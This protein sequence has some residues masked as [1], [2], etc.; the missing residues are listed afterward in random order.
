M[1]VTSETAQ[2]WEQN[3]QYQIPVAFELPYAVS[4]VVSDHFTTCRTMDW[5]ARLER[6]W[7][8]QE[9]RKADE[10]KY[11]K[12]TWIQFSERYHVEPGRI[13]DSGQAKGERFSEMLSRLL[14]SDPNS[15]H[16]AGSAL[17][18]HKLRSTITMH[19]R[20]R[21]GTEFH[22]F[23]QLPSE[24]RNMVYGLLL[25]KGTVIV[26]NNTKN[27]DIRYVKYW[28]DH[29]GAAYERY[30]GLERE[31]K[32]L[33][34]RNREREPLF[35]LHGVS[36]TFHAEAIRVYFGNNRF[37]LPSSNLFR[38]SLFGSLVRI[39]S[40]DVQEMDHRSSKE[41]EKGRNNAPLVRDVSYT[42]DM[43]DYQMEDHDNLCY[44]EELRESIDKESRSSQEA[45]R[46]LHDQKVYELEVV[47][48]E[49]IDAIKWMTLDRLDLSF[50]ECYCNTG[51]CRKVGWVLDRL[52][53]AGPPPGTTHEDVYSFVDWRTRPPLVIDV[54]GWKNDKE[55][56][57]IREKLG[58]LRESLGSIEI[59][60]GLHTNRQEPI[61]EADD[62]LLEEL[63]SGTQR[64]MLE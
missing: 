49:R 63:V 22:G 39:V 54:V 45:L 58:R 25:V 52:L 55:E 60:L 17:M 4:K 18:A 20:K 62:R 3:W 50:E 13:V 27:S 51:C 14:D 34:R 1:G 30:E 6:Y 7:C 48:A 44:N 2:R 35:L 10:D 61:L 41:F 26:P 56:K 47:W 21:I 23:L 9:K 29:Q 37:I 5:M 33:Q 40:D 59:R 42:F 57:L 28:K 32:G 64:M 8:F 16:D 36:R 46:M 24:I 19:R 38:P 43:R 12:Y 11:G 31:L 15:P 53:H